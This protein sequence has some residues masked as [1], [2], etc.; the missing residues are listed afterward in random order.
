MFLPAKQN[1]KKQLLTKKDMINAGKAYNH[2]L[3][4]DQYLEI[5]PFT[6]REKSEIKL[7]LTTKIEFAFA[8]GDFSHID[9]RMKELIKE[10]DRRKEKIK[11]EEIEDENQFYND[12]K[13]IMIRRE[14]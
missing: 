6:A 3:V 8:K 4:M 9:K 14:S 7:S 13:N 10:I 11:K 2:Y 1:M 5:M 12:M